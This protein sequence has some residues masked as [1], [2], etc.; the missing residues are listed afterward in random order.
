MTSKSKMAAIANLTNL[1]YKN[2]GI[3]QAIKMHN[4]S[5][6]TIF[7]MTNQIKWL[8]YPWDNLDL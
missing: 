7:G 1:K 5:N 4:I 3:K 2:F 6:Y 8:F